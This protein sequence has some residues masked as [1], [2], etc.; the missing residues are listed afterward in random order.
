MTDL[1]T[2]DLPDTQPAAVYRRVGVIEIDDRVVPAVEAG[3]VLVEVSHCGVC[4]TDLHLVL[5]GW[6]TPNSVE[7]H[8]YSGRVV[9]IGDGV[10]GWSIGERIV[11]GANPTCGECEACRAGQPAQCARR[12]EYSNSAYDGAFTRYTSI[13][14]SSLV[15]VPDSLDLRTAALAEPLAVALHAITRSGILA[16]ESSM[17]LGA[18]PIGALILSVLVAEGIG[19]VT[20]V[21]PSEVRQRLARQLGA[22]RVLHPD[23][24]TEFSIAEP[25][26][27]ASDA[28]SVVFE[29][30]G[31]RTAM[32]ASP[33]QLRRGGRLV[34]VGAGIDP[35]RFDPNRI[36]LT[37]LSVIGAFIY[38]AHGFEA[39]IEWLDSGRLRTDLLIEPDDVPL[40]A[41]LEAMQQVVAGIRPGKVMIVP[42][43]SGARP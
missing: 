26:R 34:L 30:S 16:G 17:I 35:P 29:C 18:G 22:H 15:R 23:E 40:D 13:D 3:R 14:A 5:E 36:I 33:S 31:R 9:A 7:G 12:G 4:G 42:R 41:M 20:V 25:D 24:L 19:P 39:A 6:G 8:E 1:P 21:E 32:E 27:I 10:H 28:V 37:E 11:C 38:D 43:L 2:P